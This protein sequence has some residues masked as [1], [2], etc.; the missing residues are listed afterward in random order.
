MRLSSALASTRPE[1]DD[2]LAGGVLF[3]QFRQWYNAP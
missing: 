2:S 3:R 1:N